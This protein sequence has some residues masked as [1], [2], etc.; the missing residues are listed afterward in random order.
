MSC[1]GGAGV[2]PSSGTD[3]GIGD[4]TGSNDTPAGGVNS[5]GAGAPISVSLPANMGRMVSGA[6]TR[7]TSYRYW[8]VWLILAVL[9]GY[10]LRGRK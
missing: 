1:C 5:I 4:W 3:V 7:V 10:W 9:I 2:R 6:V 8:Y